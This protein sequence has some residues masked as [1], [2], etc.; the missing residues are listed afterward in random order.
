MIFSKRGKE[1]RLS[2]QSARLPSHASESGST[3]LRHGRSWQWFSD[4]FCRICFPFHIEA[5]WFVSGSAVGVERVGSTLVFGWFP[6]MARQIETP[7]PSI[8]PGINW[9]R[10]VEEWRIQEFYRLIMISFY[11]EIMKCQKI[12]KSKFAEKT[13]CSI[14]F[15]N[16]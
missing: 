2:S 10:R 5:F 12:P 4:H 1:R 6:W 13:V 7:K 9:S 14:V 8:S 3:S 16:M 11:L 15:N